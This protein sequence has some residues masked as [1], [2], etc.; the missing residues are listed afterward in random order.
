[1]LYSSHGK[2]PSVLVYLP[3]RA[4]T[5]AGSSVFSRLFAWYCT[6]Q[7]RGLALTPSQPVRC[8]VLRPW[9]I[10]SS[11]VAALI[12]LLFY[13]WQSGSRAVL[14][15]HLLSHKCLFFSVVFLTIPPAPPTAHP[16]PLCLHCCAGSNPQRNTMH[17]LGK[18]CVCFRPVTVGT[19]STIIGMT[20]LLCCSSLPL[21]L[22]L[23]SG[24][25]LRLDEKLRSK[26]RRLG[27][28]SETPDSSERTGERG[29]SE[30]ALGVATDWR[31]EIRLASQLP[32]DGVVFGGSGGIE[33]DSGELE[34]ER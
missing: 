10:H 7:A 11:Q 31:E 22:A 4:G 20:Y 30:T 3:H 25:D 32:D 6:A 19:C 21:S 23:C 28:S 12:I 27:P 29:A 18:K 13:T 1:M 9:N 34:T 15:H 26:R 14:A 24:H 33:R 16:A 8:R 17:A 2:R 5:A